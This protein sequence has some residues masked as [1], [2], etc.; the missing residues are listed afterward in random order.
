M[1]E[2]WRQAGA[3]AL[4]LTALCVLAY[5][6]N[7]LHGGFISDAW[8]NRAIHVFAPDAG[9]FGKLDRFLDQPNIAARP[10]YAVYLVALNGAFGSHMGVWLAWLGATSVLMSLILYLLLRRLDFE[11]LDAGLIACLVLIFPAAGSLR[12]WAATAQIPIALSLALL[13]FLLALVAF[14]ARGARRT[15]LHCAS[16][17]SFVASLLFYETAMPLMLASVLLYRLK[18]PWS[19][20]VRRWTLDLI[21]LVSV[22]VVAAASASGAKEVQSVAG[23]WHHAG[24][25]FD[26]I[27]TLLALVVLPFGSDSWY[28]LALAGLVPLAAVL[29]AR[30]LPREDPARA[31][32]RRWLAV[33]VGGLLVVVLGYAVFVPGIDYYAPLGPGIADRVNAVPSIGWVLSLYALIMLSATLVFRGVT[34]S[35]ALTS[36]LVSLACALVAIGWM[37][38]ISRDS[39][40]YT[41]AHIEDQRVLAVIRAVL[42][43]APTHGTIWTFGQPVE[44]APGV[45]VFG[46]TWDMTTSVQLMYDDPTIRSFVG[47]P[48]TT[49]EC[50][51][52]AIVPGG[53]AAYPPADPGQPSAF[54]STYGTTYF[55]DTVTGRTEALLDPAQCRHAA[56]SFERSPPL[57]GG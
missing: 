50:A 44:I 24:T 3:V 29:V 33:L 41:S 9:F 57:P 8:A 34:G 48:G 13:G 16:L 47:F 20:A 5:G 23:M 53:H 30:W 26:Q 49:F 21:V 55:V 27:W 6:S 22:A 15:S 28:V 40:A 12:L 56:E 7:A 17:G 2:S 54:S 14:D 38:S 51:P 39:D 19:R 45:P 25:I 1:K 11:F 31:P 32:L 52:Q 37:Q 10:L 18:V 46:N 35:R 4:A 36:A 42:P 43:E